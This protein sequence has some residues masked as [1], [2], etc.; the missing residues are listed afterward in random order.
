M[1]VYVQQGSLPS[2]FSRHSSDRR[3]TQFQ[4]LAVIQDKHSALSLTLSGDRVAAG[5]AS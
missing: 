1:L 3:S 2:G 4:W 5:Q